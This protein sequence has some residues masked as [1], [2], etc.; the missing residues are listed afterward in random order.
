[1]ACFDLE[2]AQYWRT[3][4]TQE[5]NLEVVGVAK[6]P[7]DTLLKVGETQADLVVIDLP[8]SREDPGLCSHLLAEYPQLKVMAVSNSGDIGVLY[9]TGTIR[10]DLSFSSPQ[11]LRHQIQELA[12]GADLETVNQ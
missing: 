9:R 2:Q 7:V 6:D 3:L 1:M 5:G 8:P 10:L 12:H 11:V 4:L